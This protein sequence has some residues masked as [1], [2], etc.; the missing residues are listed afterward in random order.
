MK[1]KR[2][3]LERFNTVS[4][5]TRLMAILGSAILC[6]YLILGLSIA[7]M[8]QLKDTFKAVVER[9]AA[10][11]LDCM[12]LRNKTN[13]VRVELLTMLLVE[14]SKARASLKSDIKED[15]AE[16]RQLYVQ[17]K[18]CFANNKNMLD[19]VQHIENVTEA[20]F[21]TRDNELIPF[22]LQGK[23]EEALKIALGIQRERFVIMRDGTAEIG[24]AASKQAKAGVDQ[25]NARMD[26]MLWIMVGMAAFVSIALVF[27]L[28][29]TTSAIIRPISQAV[30]IASRISQGDLVDTAEI[31]SN[32]EI[33]K[34]LA[35]M[36]SMIEYLREMAAL[37][38][39]IA[40]GDLSVRVEVRN[41]SDVFGKAFKKMVESLHAII[42]ELSDSAQG[43]SSS[44][45]EMAATSNQQ[46]A[47][48]AQQASSIQESL[49][50]LEEIRITVNQA[51]EKAKS[52][53]EI[54][55][56]SLDVSRKGQEA[57]EQ[58]LLAM[59]KIRD[60]VQEIARNIIELSRKT[61]QIGEITTSVEEIAEQSNLLTVN[62]AI[63]AIRAGEAGR[64]FGVV[65]AEVKNLA[66]QS[67]RA[68][69]QVRGILDEI[70]RATSSTVMVT[71]EG[72][73]RVESGVNQ[74]H[75]IGTNFNRLY[76]VI[77]ESSN[78]AKQIAS[79]TY[80]QVAGIEQIAMG[81]R[82]ISQAA[83]DS[84][85]GAKQQSI[86]AQNLS[87]LAASINSIVQ[88]YRL[89]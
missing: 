61:V 65:A 34:L 62:A 54:S 16:I 29:M 63:E 33:G 17:V 86:T 72:S 2:T 55:E 88:R 44:A 52:V 66:H 4:I 69:A 80:Q 56:H 13:K 50:T 73:K 51:S 23:K 35:S 27:L 71:E 9:D 1:M 74:V 12:S 48:I 22:I 77:V 15:T 30:E 84:A 70:Q 6:V 41:E 26:Q 49:A 5:K 89:N 18:Q 14:D 32:D 21:Q 43:L 76:G 10:I 31:T 25:A 42:Q 85:T 59:V 83:N 28:L 11:A 46:S 24:K 38:D 53:V 47:M 78:A 58:S 39:S 60:Q 57:L 45:S 79:A 40:S 75:E 19:K 64:G 37:A 20:F 82:T 68:T 8:S 3:I 87:G 7:D 81:M 67:K 36:N